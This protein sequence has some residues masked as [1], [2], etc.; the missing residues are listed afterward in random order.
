MSKC[1]EK[2]L[3]IISIKKFVEHLLYVRL[4]IKCLGGDNEIKLGSF[5]VEL[6][7]RYIIFLYFVINS[8]KNISKGE[9]LCKILG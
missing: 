6:I 1:L 2:R 7:C 3:K 5:L 8:Q 9:R 4:Y